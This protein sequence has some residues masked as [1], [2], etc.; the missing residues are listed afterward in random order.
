VGTA[1]FIEREHHLPGSLFASSTPTPSLSRAR[2]EH[3]T[4]V[5]P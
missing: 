4:L 5:G 1:G 2:I 3:R